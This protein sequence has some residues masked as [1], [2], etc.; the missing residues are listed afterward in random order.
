[1]KTS[2]PLKRKTALKSYSHLTARVSFKKGVISP[3]MTK[4]RQKPSLKTRKG[5]PTDQKGI[6]D[7]IFSQCIRRAHA[8]HRGYV[9]CVTCSAVGHWRSFDN[10][11]FQKREHMATRFDPRNCAPQCEDCNRFNDGMNEEFAAYIDRVHGAGMAEELVRLADTTV[12]DFPYKE[13]IEEWTIVLNKLIA[14]G[15]NDIQY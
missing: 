7:A 11:H 13:K 14:K 9:V 5:P 12:H 6:L 2:T 10:G 15:G 8:D 1:M 3:F 4:N